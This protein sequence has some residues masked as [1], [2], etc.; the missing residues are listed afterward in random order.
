[1]ARNP[2]GTGPT[3]GN[4]TGDQLN[5]YNVL[6][7]ELK[8]YQNLLNKTKS[9]RNKIKDIL[10][11]F[12]N[13][14]AGDIILDIIPDESSDEILNSAIISKSDIVNKL[15]GINTDI[16]QSSNQ[17][18]S[19]Y[20]SYGYDNFYSN[21]TSNDIYRAKSMLNTI[22]NKNVIKELIARSS[23]LNEDELYVPIYYQMIDQSNSTIA[24]KDLLKDVIEEIEASLL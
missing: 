11:N 16:N 21:Y 4:L 10:D 23:A 15:N 3:T 24:A 13:I 7:E 6:K 9:K 22:F 14:I 17:G 8:Y 20:D 19:G 1:M 18:A 5:E 2:Q 12:E